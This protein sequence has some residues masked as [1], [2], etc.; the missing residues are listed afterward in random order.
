MEAIDF[1]LG[2]NYN[3]NAAA[4]GV[5]IWA[6]TDSGCNTSQAPNYGFGNLVVI[7]HGSI[8]TYYA[9]LSEILVSEGQGVDIT[10]VIGREGGTG[11]AEG[12]HLHFEARTGIIESNPVITGSALSIRDLTGITWNTSAGCPWNGI[13]TPP[14]VACGSA[15]GP[16]L[17][18][19]YLQVEVG[20]YDVTVKYP[21]VTVVPGPFNP[22]HTRRDLAVQVF[23]GSNVRVYNSTISVNYDRNRNI[24]IGTADLGSSFSSGTHIVSK[25]E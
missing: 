12:A 4:G 21:D 9:H 2:A 17:I 8:Y 7:K 19:T 24:F 13:G 1:S 6:K 10:T 18:S 15:N 11:C 23:N 3:V 16:S 25:T 14:S 22:L 20:I 5:V